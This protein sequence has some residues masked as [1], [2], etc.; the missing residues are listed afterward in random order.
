MLGLKVQD[1]ADFGA[2]I[3]RKVRDHGGLSRVELARELGVAAST[4]GRHVDALVASGYFTETVEPTKEA[5]RPPTKLR[6]NPGKGCFI[7][8]DFHISSLFATVV[9]F[10]QQVVVQKSIA[11]DGTRGAKHLLQQVTT[12]VKEIAKASP[13]PLLAAGIATPGRVDSQRGIALNY[14]FVDGF[15]DIPLAE[16]ISAELHVPVYIENNIR[17]M[18]LAERWFGR[19]LGCQDL[20]CLGARIGVSAGVIR[21]GELATGHRELGGEIRGWNCPTF[22]AVN[23]TWNWSRDSILESAASVTAVLARYQQLSGLSVDQQTYLE[24]AAAG[25]AHALI[26]LK[27]AASAQ[28]WA[29]SQMAQIIDPEVVVLAGPLTALGDVYLNTVNEVALQ[30]E[31]VYHP[32][33]PIYL[34][35]LGEQAGAFGASAL[36]LSRWRPIDLR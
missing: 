6:P 31:S 13:Y 7:G 1:N 14:I 29:I 28:G 27:E 24:A 10:A 17:T 5:G 36:A 11:V 35:E 30:F 23:E 2:E 34:S 32:S 21:N 22:D 19:G 4:V 18:A 20:I 33:M 15:K 12:A 8:I 9:D 25:D 3:I 26:A 16:L